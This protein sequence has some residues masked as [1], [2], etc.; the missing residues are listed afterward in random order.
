[1]KITLT[2]SEQFTGANI[3]IYRRIQSLQK[4][5]QDT[6]PVDHDYWTIDVEG[7]MAELAVANV[8]ERYWPGGVNTYTSPD[9]PPNI[10]VRWTYRLDGSLIVRKK[11]KDDHIFVLVTGRCPNYNVCGWIRGSD[12]KVPKHLRDPHQAGE[13]YFVPQSFLRNIYEDF[14]SA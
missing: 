14:E 6:V 7:A 3:G 9:I 5:S 4:N 8:L 2:T 1:M 13:S 11:D 10:Q 12:A